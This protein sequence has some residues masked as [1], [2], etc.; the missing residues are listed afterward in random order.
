MITKSVTVVVGAIVLSGCLATSDERTASNDDQRITKIQG[1]AIGAGAGALI[2][3]LAGDTKGAIWGVLIGGGLGYLAGNEVGRRKAA[4]VK[5]EDFLDAEIAQA[6]NINK[7]LVAYN[8]NL[9]KEINSLDAKSKRLA[10]SYQSG[11]T[12]RNDLRA[13][14]ETVQAH[15]KTSRDLEKRLKKEQEIKLSVLE[16]QKKHRAPD[17]PHVRSL[18]KQVRELQTNIEALQRGSTQLAQIDERL[19][20]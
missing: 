14:R 10:A 2:G 7:E 4:Y 12:S 13:Q 8:A 1:T 18:E 3:A 19:S 15:W 16:D 6:R 5:E 20:V 11:K 17:D 9:R